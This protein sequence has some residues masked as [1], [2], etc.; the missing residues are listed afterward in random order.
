M[1][2]IAKASTVAR[3]IIGGKEPSGATINQKHP[4]YQS[5][6]TAAFQWYNMNRD[7]KDARKYLVELAKKLNWE[8]KYIAG[9]QDLDNDEVSKTI[10]W[11]AR[12]LMSG[13]V[14]SPKH[15]SVLND[16]MARIKALVDAKEAMA[17]AAASAKAAPATPV[18]SVQDHIR[19]KAQELLGELEGEI[20]AFLEGKPKYTEDKGYFNHLRGRGLPQAYVPYIVAWADEKIREFGT[21]L[22]TKDV[23]IKEAYSNITKRKTS[24]LV[25]WLA[26]IKNQAA[27]YG[28]FKKVNRAPRQRKAK[29]ASVQVAKMKY[30]TSDDAFKIKSVVPAEVIGADQ[31]WTF[32][33]KT[34]V[35]AVY[36]ATGPQGLGVKGTTI[37]N[38]DTETSKQKRLRKP[39]AIL[40]KV[41]GGGKVSLRKLLDEVKAVEYTPNG[42]ISVDTVLLRVA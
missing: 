28:Q 16:R 35:L 37:I 8:K 15:E 39:E 13:A 7:V 3:D 21:V 5:E 40:S 10:G 36:R 19:E 22:V 31:L 4:G 17:K 18:K 6:L 20:D 2:R 32:N 26:A 24:D 9:I 41:V 23:Q 25:K 33:T 38:Y 1:A 27:D 42:R 30:K 11:C 34:R 29:P 14:L 12:L